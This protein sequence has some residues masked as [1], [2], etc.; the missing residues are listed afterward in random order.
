MATDF[1]T[2]LDA[3]TNPAAANTLAS[4]SHAGQHTNAND[5]IEALEAKVGVDGSVVATSLDYLVRKGVAIVSATAPTS[6]VANQLWY[7]I[8]NELMKRWDATANA[9]AGAWVAEGSA[10]YVAQGASPVEVL[11]DTVLGADGSIT[12]SSIPGTYRH[13]RMIVSG[14]SARAT[15]TSDNIAIRFNADTAANY[16]SQ[17]LEAYGATVVGSE[18]L[19]VS[20]LRVGAFPAAGAA[21]ELSGSIVIDIPGYAG[22][23]NKSFTSL[24]QFRLGTASGDMRLGHRAGQWRNTAAITTIALFGENANLLAGTVAT[25]YGMET[26]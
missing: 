12:F 1:P 20:S 26:A 10:A 19:G 21:A 22:A 4:P 3:L 18:L 11:A 9:G 8:A 17:A 13:L 23:L 7:D 16:D 2:G 5:A 24:N 15:L 25:L 14:R 6:P